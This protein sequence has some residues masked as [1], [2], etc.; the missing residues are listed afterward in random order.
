MLSRPWMRVAAALVL[1]LA[2]LAGSRAWSDWPGFPRLFADHNRES[3]RQLQEQE[4]LYL[5]AL[6]GRDAALW[7]RLLSEDFVFADS[8]GTMGKRAFIDFAT[9]QLPPDLT[10]AS[11]IEVLRTYGDAGTVV[12]LLTITGEGGQSQERFSHSWVRRSGR[13]YIIATQ[14]SEIAPPGG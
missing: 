10:F 11:S 5:Q 3:A 1:G 6:N 14:V 4:R 2:V 8:T 13:W 7:D 12:A 9:T